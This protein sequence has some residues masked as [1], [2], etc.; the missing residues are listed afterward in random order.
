MLADSACK[1]RM[2]TDYQGLVSP[3]SADSANCLSFS[4]Q[5]GPGVHRFGLTHILGTRI[6]VVL[7]P[8]SCAARP[9]AEIIWPPTDE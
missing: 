4:A 2:C 7:G 1:A 3:G 8:K 9:P 6:P 5:A